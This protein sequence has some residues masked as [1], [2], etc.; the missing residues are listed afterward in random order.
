MTSSSVMARKLG[1]SLLKHPVSVRVLSAIT[2]GKVRNLISSLRDD[3]EENNDNNSMVQVTLYFLGTHINPH[4][5][6]QR[7]LQGLTLTRLSN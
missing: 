7:M 6:G 4:T 1:H 2:A 5:E 3:E